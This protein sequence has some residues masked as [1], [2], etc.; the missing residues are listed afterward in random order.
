[1]LKFLYIYCIHVFLIS[2][3]PQSLSYKKE[4]SIIA[5]DLNK[6]TTINISMIAYPVDVT[7]HWSFG[8]MNKTWESVNETSGQYNITTIGLTSYLIITSFNHT[9][10]YS[11]RFI[12]KMVRRREEIMDF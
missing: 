1:M 2:D 10:K 7:F 6:P 11:T 4:Q 5:A 12:V 9:T 8:G 3:S